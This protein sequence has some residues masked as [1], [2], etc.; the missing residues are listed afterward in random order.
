MNND[1][2]LNKEY[3]YK[4][5]NYQ[6]VYANASKVKMTPWDLTLVFGSQKLVADTSNEVMVDEKIG[7]TLSPYHFKAFVSAMNNVLENFETQ[8][9]A[10]NLKSDFISS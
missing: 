9:G 1:I 3:K 8:F 10:I 4:Y 7:V 6:E 2:D 5:D